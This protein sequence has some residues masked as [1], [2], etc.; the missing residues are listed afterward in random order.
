MP[1]QAKWFG[2]SLALHLT[3]AVS[4]ILMASRNVEQTPKAIMVVLDNLTPPNH[5]RKISARPTTRPVVQ[6]RRT[7][8]VK[9]EVLPQLRQPAMPQV[10]P[11]KAMPEQSRTK[12]LPIAAPEVPAISDSRPKIGPANPAAPSQAKIPVQHSIAKA[13]ER[14]AP[15]KAQQRYL[16]EH[17][18]YIRDLITKQLVYPPMARKMRWSGKVVVAFII[19]ED[20]TVHNIRVLETSGFPILDKGAAETV[21]NTAPF[22]KPPVRAEIVVPIRFNMM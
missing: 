7:E 12:E 5:P 14:P 19:A 16:K 6:D 3:V 4:L 10:Q 17:F 15:E 1:L 11:A 8:A 9:P 18:T 22:P 21:R 20:G 2:L 13:E